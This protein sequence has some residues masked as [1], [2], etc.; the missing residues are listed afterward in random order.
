MLK[1]HP[2]YFLSLIAFLFSCAE[3]ETP[4]TDFGLDY[5]PLEVGL[6]WEYEV[7]ETIVFGESDEES[8]TFFLKDRIIYNYFN[9]FYYQL[10][11]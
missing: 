7:N 4:Q 11:P 3:T 2:L 1:I 5:Q 9:T 8:S 10:Q 6:F